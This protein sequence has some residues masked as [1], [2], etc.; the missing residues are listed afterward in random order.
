VIETIENILQAALAA[1]L[2]AMILIMCWYAVK[3]D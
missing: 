1:W 3:G 2:L